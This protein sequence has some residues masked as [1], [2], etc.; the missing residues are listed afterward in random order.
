ME[1][2][3]QG[4]A[5]RVV[6]DVPTEVRSLN[7]QIVRYIHSLRIKPSGAP[8]SGYVIVQYPGCAPFQNRM[9]L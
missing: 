6:L 5:S 9:G 1:F 8:I 7:N 3:P 2:N 4:I